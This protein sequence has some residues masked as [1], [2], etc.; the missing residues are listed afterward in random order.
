MAK[1]TRKKPFRFSAKSLA[2]E[3]ASGSDVYSLQT[4]LARYG[5]LAGAYRPGSY[6]EATRQAVSQFQSFYRIYPEQD[7]ACDEET[8]N[9]LNQPR[10]GVPDGSPSSRSAAGRLAPFVTVGARW[11]QTSLAF[12]FLNSTPDLPEQRQRDIIREAFQRWSQVSALT[13]NE[14]GEND[15]SELSIV[16]AM[17]MALPLTMPVDPT[18][19]RWRTPSSPHPVEAPRRAR[20]TSMSSSSGRI[21]RVGLGLV[22]TT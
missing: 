14:V 4:L 1:E 5:H 7:G 9:L 20:F 16:E 6:D 2:P 15:S 18:E 12:R 22:S 21:N 8:I 19:T 11:P 3:T 10:C 17:E 13:F